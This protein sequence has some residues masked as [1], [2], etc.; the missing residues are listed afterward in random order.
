MGRFKP[1]EKKDAIKIAVI[2]G[3]IVGPLLFALSL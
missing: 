2:T 3:I 1:L